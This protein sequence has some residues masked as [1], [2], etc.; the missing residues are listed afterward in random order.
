MATMSRQGFT[1]RITVTP[2]IETSQYVT[3]DLVGEKLTFSGAFLGQNGP[4]TGVVQSIVLKDAD[5]KSAALDI[6]LFD[7][8][9]SGTTFTDNAAFDVADADLTKIVGVVSLTTYFAFNDNSVSYSGDLNMPFEIAA[10]GSALYGAIVSR[11][12]VTYTAGT[13]LAVT[14]G[15]MFG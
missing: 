3:G 2:T 4:S 7:S 11:A 12:T 1:K 6:V 9:P 13:D 14:I 5:K 8:D 10:G 15:V